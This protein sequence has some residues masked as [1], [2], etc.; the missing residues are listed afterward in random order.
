MGGLEPYALIWSP[1]SD[2]ALEPAQF[3]TDQTV[4]ILAHDGPLAVSVA[5]DGVNYLCSGCSRL[6]LRCVRCGGISA[7]PKRDAGEPIP[8]Y[9]V[10]APAG[11]YLLG[12]QLNVPGPG[13]FA[14]RVA[15]EDYAFEVGASYSERARQHVAMFPSGMSPE[16]LRQI[17]AMG[18]SVLGVH[19]DRFDAMYERSKR[20]S[21]QA[22]DHHRLVDLI[23]YG[24]KAANQI[25]SAGRRRQV[26]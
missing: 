5:S 16:T 18:R 20:H 8:S 14:A 19:F 10:V 26:T 9:S 25:E 3:E 12:S 7:T 4:L 1:M 21:T 2:I 11:Q 22:P 6:V 23:R 15:A 24:D 17:S 13:V